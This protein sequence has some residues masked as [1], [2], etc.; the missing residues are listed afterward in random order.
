VKNDDR[1]FLTPDEAE[2]RIRSIASDLRRI[3]AGV[4]DVQI[5]SEEHQYYSVS[6]INPKA[7]GFSFILDQWLDIEPAG[8]RWELDWTEDG[9]RRF[10]RM[11]E[12]IAAGRIVAHQGQRKSYV[13]IALDDGEIERSTVMSGLFGLFAPRNKIATTFEPW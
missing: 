6:P 7:C 1:V 4:A 10:W 11:V 5:D 9:I 3:Y 2:E 12:S 8:G 13:E